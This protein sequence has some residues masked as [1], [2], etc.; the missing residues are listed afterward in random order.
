MELKTENLTYKEAITILNNINVH[1]NPGTVSVILSSNYKKIKTLL[2]IISLNQKPTSGNIIVDNNIVNKKN[3]QDLK[4]Y[5]ALCTN[6][7]K[8]TVKEELES[9]LKKYKN[10]INDKRIKDT[11][12]MVN[13][14][15]CC[16]D[17]N[18]NTLSSGEKQKLSI[19]LT[20]IYNP[21]IIIFQEPTKNL[22]SQAKKSLLKLLKLMKLRYNKT[23]VIATKDEDTILTLADD[24]YVL[25]Q[26]NTLKYENKYEFFK[27]EVVKKLPINYPKTIEF[28]RIIKKQK[29]KNIPYRDD[30]NDLIKDIYRVIN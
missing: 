25:D 30:I 12:R 3:F 1:F 27:S 11:M 2:N 15:T 19:A 21:K 7:I 23:L 13:L 18:P 26:K 24:I 10:I 22:D 17:Q 29:N 14:P 9:N 4:K 20:L 5:I 16:L 28:A 8:D 6:H